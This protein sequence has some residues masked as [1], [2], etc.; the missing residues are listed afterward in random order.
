[1]H[2]RD[3]IVKKLPMRPNLDS[4]FR[5]FHAGNI[6]V[7]PRV[8]AG[9]KL[10]QPSRI[11]FSLSADRLRAQLDVEYGTDFQEHSALPGLMRRAAAIDGV[12]W[13]RVLYCYPDETSDELLD[14]LA[15]KENICPYLDIPI[16]HI[17]R[18]ILRKMHRRGRASRSRRCR[19]ARG[20]KLS[21]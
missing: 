12:D 11:R 20:W 17:N 21:A 16:Q 7:N 1:M 3:I 10:H 18:E 14:L 8:V 5:A 4:L 15:E 2:K 13:L 6:S 9:G 19:K